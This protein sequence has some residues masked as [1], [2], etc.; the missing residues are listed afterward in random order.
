MRN[1]V[2][3]DRLPPHSEDAEQATLGCLLLDSKLCVPIA[4]GRLHPDA[5]YD[6]RH[7]TLY[8]AILEIFEKNG[9][10][11]VITL[12]DHLRK[13]K[14]LEQ[15]N[16][17]PYIAGLMNVPP[18]ASSLEHYLEI[19]IE[20]HTMRKIIY[21]C[22]SMVEKAYDNPKSKD[23]LPELQKAVMEL[24]PATGNSEDIA[25]K[26]LMVRVKDRIENYKD[27]ESKTRGFSTGFIDLDNVW[28]GMKLTQL[29]I[30]AA[31]PSIGKSSL[32]L[33]IAENVATA[34]EP[35][36]VFSME[37]EA[38][39]LGERS[40]ANGASVDGETIQNGTYDHD[41]AAAMA[42]IIRA[43]RKLPI[44]ICEQGGMNF[45]Y[46]RARLRRMVQRH[47]IKLAVIDYLQ[48]FQLPC[49]ENRSI[50]IGAIT[51]GLK[52]LAKELRIVI[53]CLSQLNR[54]LEKDNRR[55]RMSDLRDSGSIEQDAD[56]IL[57]L[58]EDQ[59]DA[60]KKTEDRDQDTVV[61]IGDIPKNRGGKRGMVR[62][63]F[64][65]QFTRFENM[66]KIDLDLD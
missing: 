6:G 26:D 57:L 30:I 45:A 8:R 60:K 15:V 35:V 29:I 11:E 27:P 4:Q 42:A 55:P 66:P 2:K 58:S 56:K 65:R 43:R 53:I 23:T 52:A 63:R 3:K 37:M 51:T 7:E 46:F 32:A 10:V 64:R 20:A 13:A 16:G 40:V 59:E 54:D 24:D 33:N 5:F 41:Q 12:V 44:Y 17:A 49:R 34:G 62:F 36:G 1:E 47:K 25:M 9:H 14:Q 22:T 48:L 28:N 50:E 21:L 61:I 31:R 18:S 38:E 19:V 39:E